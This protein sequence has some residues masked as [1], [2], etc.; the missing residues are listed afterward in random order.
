MVLPDEGVGEIDHE[1]RA[2]EH[3]QVEAVVCVKLKLVAVGLSLAELPEERALGAERV[4][5]ELEPLERQRQRREV[6]VFNLELILPAVHHGDLH[7][8]RR[9]NEDGAVGLCGQRLLP[10][11]VLNRRA[12]ALCP[13][14]VFERHAGGYLELAGG[15]LVGGNRRLVRIAGIGHARPSVGLHR[16]GGNFPTPIEHPFTLDVVNVRVRS[17]SVVGARAAVH[18]RHQQGECEQAARHPDAGRLSR[19]R[20]APESIRGDGNDCRVGL[21]TTVLDRILRV[22]PPSRRGQEDYSTTR[23]SSRFQRR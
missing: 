5:H 13:S 6:D 22:Y 15:Q 12:A 10:A 9:G 7:R 16:P 18:G 4:H 19:D 1:L 23:V 17:V 11:Q 14:Q 20:H 8:C 21:S 3:F 2:R